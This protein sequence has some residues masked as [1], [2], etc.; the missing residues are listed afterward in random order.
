MD[1]NLGTISLS[2][3]IL[4]KSNIGLWAF[5]LDENCKPRMYVNNT[6]L[7]LLGLTKQISPED[8]YHAWYDNIDSSSYELVEKTVKKMKAGEH[9]EVQYPWKHPNGQI[10]YVRC[11]GARNFSYTKGIRIEGYHQNVTEIVHY[12]QESIEKTKKLSSYNTI[13]D[14]ISEDYET[15]LNIDLA[16][17]EQIVFKNLDEKA[18]PY[19]LDGLNFF[20]TINKYV[21]N[22][23]VEEDKKRFKES[24]K[25]ELIAAKIST[26][27]PYFVNYKDNHHKKIR[28]MQLKFIKNIND[29]NKNSCIVSFRNVTQD[30]LEEE[31]KIEENAVISGLA[32][33]FNHVSYTDQFSSSQGNSIDISNVR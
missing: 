10:M 11:G 4:T 12:Q 31:K 3:D 32:E 28:W 20:E 27:E 24:I 18:A 21:I 13:L 9:A 6:M 17:G 19:S 23:I 14:S 16:T 30:H 26:G 33:D 22:H 8:T 25:P 5:E 2:P 29:I 7:E 1:L 15:I